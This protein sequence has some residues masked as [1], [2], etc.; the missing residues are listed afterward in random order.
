MGVVSCQSVCHN[1]FMPH[2]YQFCYRIVSS[3]PYSRVWNSGWYGYR[4]CDVR[5]SVGGPYHRLKEV[6]K[7]LCRLDDFTLTGSDLDYDGDNESDSDMEPHDLIQTATETKVDNDSHAA[8]SIAN[9]EHTDDDYNLSDDT[10]Q[11]I[12]ETELDDYNLSDDTIQYIPE[13]ELDDY[14]LSDDTIQYIPET[15]VDTD[16]TKLDSDCIIIDTD[17][18]FTRLNSDSD[19]TRL[20]SDTTSDTTP[21][22][23]RQERLPQRQQYST[24]TKQLKRNAGILTN[25]DDTSTDTTPLLIQTDTRKRKQRPKRL[26]TAT[27]MT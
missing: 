18:D 7:A 14:N 21:L 22:L 13:T 11:Y 17:S 16:S 15:E 3:L 6:K 23:F 5:V 4:V 27:D 19:S 24:T 26:F 20:N 10:I 9:T 8:D 2:T 25:N 12:P 1:Y